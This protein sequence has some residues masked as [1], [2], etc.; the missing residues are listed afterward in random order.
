MYAT[1]GLAKVL[2]MSAEQLVGKSF[3]FCIQENCL[4]EAVKC[5]E[6]AK[7][8]DSIAYLRFWYRTPDDSDVNQADEHM[9]DGHSSD[10]DEGGV[11]LD[12]HMQS[13][14]EYS[15]KRDPFK[16]YSRVDWSTHSTGSEDSP[17][18][19][20]RISSETTTDAE[21]PVARHLFET[22]ERR[23]SSNSSVSDGN[24]VQDDTEEAIELEAVV[25]CT[26]DGLVVILREA[27]PFVPASVRVPQ[28]VAKPNHNTG[29]FASPWANQPILPPLPQTTFSS[30]PYFYPGLSCP[31]AP[32]PNYPAATAI[33]PP[34]PP[35]PSGPTVD[36]FMSS[37][38]DV[39]VFA[40]SLTG[41]NGSL[42]QFSRGRPRG[43]AVPGAGMPVWD[44]ASGAG[45]ESEH[46]N[47]LYLNDRP[48]RNYIPPETTALPPVYG[49]R[50]PIPGANPAT[51]LARGSPGFIPRS[52]NADV[53]KY[54]PVIVPQGEQAWRRI[55]EPQA[56]KQHH[57]GWENGSPILRRSQHVMSMQ[58][59]V[60]QEAV[61]NGG[62][63][64]NMG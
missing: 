9:S 19:N 36:D 42:A 28:R 46:F 41:I 40:W 50:Y 21:A 26:S 23:I 58:K 1:N 10:Q 55:N 62:E 11:V 39:A 31:P 8:N 16:P 18:P 2:G 38:R 53:N 3:Y 24:Y 13:D 47:G 17:D 34:L 5:L 54:W 52:P 57:Q 64:V 49:P 29:V 37:I 30:R 61:T 4:A 44:P 12:G 15:T 33:S 48:R 20:S 7:E 25:S 63:D 59:R 14:G 51:A 22:P 35:L 45:L 56:R 43:Y 27:R 6:G 60:G 32:Q